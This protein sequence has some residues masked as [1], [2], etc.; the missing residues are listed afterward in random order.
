M[1][2]ICN[3]CEVIFGYWFHGIET[4]LD[5]IEKLLNLNYF[6]NIFEWKLF[7]RAIA[8]LIIVKIAC[9]SDDNGWQL[10]ISTKTF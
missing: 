4:A 8:I 10:K 1:Q 7:V 6:G 3:Y 5:C 9:T 2:Y